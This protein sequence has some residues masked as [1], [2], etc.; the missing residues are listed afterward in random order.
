MFLQLP[1]ALAQSP[2]IPSHQLR[3]KKSGEKKRMVDSTHSQTFV[4]KLLS[5]QQLLVD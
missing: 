2:N 5:K 1:F 4:E 3:R